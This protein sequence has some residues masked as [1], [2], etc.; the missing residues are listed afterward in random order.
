MFGARLVGFARAISVVM[1]QGRSSH[2]RQLSGKR[3]WYSAASI[4]GV[5]M[6]AVG[7]SSTSLFLPARSGSRHDADHG[8]PV[9]PGGIVR[10]RL[11]WPISSVTALQYVL[12]DGRGN[13]MRYHGIGMDKWYKFITPL[14]GMM[15]RQAVLINGGCLGR[16]AGQPEKHRYYL[17]SEVANGFRPAAENKKRSVF[18]FFL[19]SAGYGAFFHIGRLFT[20]CT[21]GFRP[22]S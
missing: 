11:S 17:G 16:I 19:L 15:S 18:L 10:K 14:F 2:R 6:L 20:A 4:S 21:A 12:A 9:G 22:D 5:G 1:D 8:A 3:R 13:G 7:T